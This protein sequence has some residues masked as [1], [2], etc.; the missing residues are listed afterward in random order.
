MKKI[1]YTK[2]TFWSLLFILQLSCK[3]ELPKPYTVELPEKE[4]KTDPDKEKY[5]QS[6]TIAEKNYEIKSFR[7]ENL[8]DD[9]DY[10]R[11]AVSE[12]SLEDQNGFK[13]LAHIVRMDVRALQNGLMI[14]PHMG[15]TYI[16]NKATP[17]NI[18]KAN[19]IG[20]KRV[21]ATINGDFFVMT[22]EGTFLGGMI[23]N[24][25][26]IKTP[27]ADWKLVY[28]LTV[29]NSFFIDQ[30]NYTITVGDDN[31]PINSINGPRLGDHLVL[32]TSSKGAKTGTNPWGSEILLK[33]VEGDWESLGS[34]DNV[35]CEVVSDR[36]LAV[37]GGIAIP[38]GDIVLSGHG[39]GVAICNRYRK[40]DKIA[41]NVSKPK[42]KD[43]KEYS[44]KQAIGAAYPLLLGG[45]VQPITSTSG[46]PKGREPRT[47]I[48]HSE[49]F[50]YMFVV[51]GRSEAS[52][53][54]SAIE[55]AHLLKHFGVTDGVNLDG[56]GSSMLAIGNDLF[57]QPAGTTW[58]RPVPNAL[59]IVRKQ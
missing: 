21:V 4:V 24:N 17:L 39:A 31:Y 52:D 29:N 11:I 32:Y 35:I 3:N 51:E 18:L 56:G 6:I 40:G 8:T 36:P 50:F 5:G 13:L 38:K 47:A 12:Q 20:E 14:Q 33:P 41:V 22:D 54:L 9:V 59:S 1:F 46:N 45:E 28:G 19:A 55:L 43:G 26:V 25:S 10:M 44:V 57:G 58:F 34:Y 23:Q 37:D 48:G 16:N 49:D 2:A 15:G 7:K 53:G 27:N 30:L 42:G